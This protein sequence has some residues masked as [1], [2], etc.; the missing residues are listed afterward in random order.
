MKSMQG[1]GLVIYKPYSVSG[2]CLTGETHSKL[3][4]PISSLDTL[5]YVRSFQ[6]ILK[7]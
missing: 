1:Q 7:T 6:D 2:P 4:S 3:N 5:R